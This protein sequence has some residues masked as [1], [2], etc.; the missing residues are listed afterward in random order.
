[1]IQ[2]RSLL[3]CVRVSTDLRFTTTFQMSL[4]EYLELSHT[5]RV[6]DMHRL[7]AVKARMRPGFGIDYSEFSYQN[8]Q[9]MDWLHL[10]QYY[11]CYFQVFF[12]TINL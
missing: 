5:F 3:V 11:N 1:M 6:G 9:A 7:A 10:A 4:E 12:K 8:L 2:F